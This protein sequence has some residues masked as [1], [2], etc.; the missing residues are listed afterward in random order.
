MNIGMKGIIVDNKKLTSTIKDLKKEIGILEKE[1]LKRKN[2]YTTIFREF[3][4]VRG[5]IGYLESS[6]YNQKGETEK[7]FTHI[8]DELTAIQSTLDFFTSDGEGEHEE[9]TGHEEIEEEKK[10]KK[11]KRLVM[12]VDFSDAIII[13]KKT[14]T[15]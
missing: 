14:K 1:N 8:E 5:R 15:K 6:N 2:Q 12:G 9:I 3:K 4:K 7:H 11:P 13:D 10:E